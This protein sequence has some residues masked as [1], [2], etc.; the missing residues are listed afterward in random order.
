MNPEKQMVSSLME[1]LNPLCDQV[2]LGYAGTGLDND[3]KPPAILV[4]LE[5]ITELE[6]Q[7]CRRK[8][9]FQF[10][11]SAVV[12]TDEGTTYALLEL[13]RSIREAMDSN[14]RLCPAA[15]KLIFSET[16]FDIAPNNSHL[17]FA[18]MALIVEAVF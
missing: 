9:Q 7:G 6:Q 16:Q 3:L 4:Q 5:S 13:S 14:E 1:R 11:L 15:R 10:N 17:S 2:L 12:A 8:Y 18:D